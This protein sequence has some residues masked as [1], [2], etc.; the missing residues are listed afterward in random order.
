VG[1]FR[2]VDGDLVAMG[3]LDVFAKL[4]DVAEFVVKF[5][6]FHVYGAGVGK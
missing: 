3:T 5:K 2:E 6:G 1:V 4:V